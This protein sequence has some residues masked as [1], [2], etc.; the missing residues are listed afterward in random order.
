MVVHGVLQRCCKHAEG[1]TNRSF[2]QE[3]WLPCQPD[4]RLPVGFVAV[5]HQ[6]IADS[7]VARKHQAEWRVREKRA[8]LSGYESGTATTSHSRSS[9]GVPAQT[10]CNGQ[11]GPYAELILTIEA[12][13]PSRNHCDFSRPLGVGLHVAQQPV[14]K[15]VAGVLSVESH[16]W[17]R[18]ILCVFRG[19]LVL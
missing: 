12:V 18:R 13:L 3:A 14:S 11:I 15:P 5:R 10:C 6:A 9:V 19:V 1:G 17:G 16:D 8:L 2:R 4:T 7:L